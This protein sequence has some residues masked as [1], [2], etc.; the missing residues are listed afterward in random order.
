MQ[1]FELER[2]Q[3]A[4]TN[5]VTDKLIVPDCLPHYFLLVSM[6]TLLCSDFL[7]QTSDLCVQ[8]FCAPV[9][10]LPHWADLFGLLYE[11]LNSK[12]Q[13]ARYDSPL[14]WVCITLMG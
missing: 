4:A 11:F 8:T 5:P 10:R 3:W 7:S 9:D 13:K 2:N 14:P 1:R 12:A 6:A